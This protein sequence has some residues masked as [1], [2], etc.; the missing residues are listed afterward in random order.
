LDAMIV[1]MKV[2][3]ARARDLLA[4]VDCG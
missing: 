1:Q 2:D 3:S 4:K